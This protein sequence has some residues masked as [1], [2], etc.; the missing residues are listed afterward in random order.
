MVSVNTIMKI[1]KIDV[2]HL[3]PPEP[4]TAILSALAR[5]DPSQ[6]ILVTHRRQ[7]FPLYEK[8]NQAGW[9]YHCI[10]LAE[11]EFQIYIFRANSIDQF[12]SLLASQQQGKI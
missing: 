10:K 2:S 7:P 12:E 3:T 8:L 5:L 11:E 4:M 6:C 1:V 9:G